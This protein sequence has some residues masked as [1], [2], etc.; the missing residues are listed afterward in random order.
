MAIME[1]F[2][3]AP[4]PRGRPRQFDRD[5]ALDTAM[6]LFWKRGFEAVSVL[7]LSGAIGINPPSLYAA[8]GDKKQLFREAIRHYQK[9][10]GNF[11][12][13]ALSGKQTAREA[14]ESLLLAAAEAYT[15]ASCPPGCMVTHAGVNCT[16]GSDDIVR[17]LAEIRSGLQTAVTECILEGQ[18][19]GDVSATV[20]AASLGA[21]FSAV[22]Q[23]MST[24]AR[25]G[26]S[27]ETVRVIARQAM[28]SWPDTG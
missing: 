6:R 16:V 11:A 18:R 7:D 14:V 23:G 4:R 2:A 15:D 10:A 3:E 12:G 22:L 26:A 20:S 25:D 28:K 24:H 5:A 13:P 8:F 19:H 27:A 1:T 17:E 21:Y 9:G